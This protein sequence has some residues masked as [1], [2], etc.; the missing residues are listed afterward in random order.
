MNLSLWC[1]FYVKLIATYYRKGV[2]GMTRKTRTF[3][4]CILVEM[5]TVESVSRC[6]LKSLLRFWHAR[7]AAIVWYIEHIAYGFLS[8]RYIRNIP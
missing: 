1:R 7:S 8:Q 5:N 2:K 3:C 6:A 4:T